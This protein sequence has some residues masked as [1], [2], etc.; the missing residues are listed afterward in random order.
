ME[1]T[2]LRS[3]HNKLLKVHMVKGFIILLCNALLIWFVADFSYKSGAH[4]HL[5][6]TT[7]AE[8][9]NSYVTLY[10]L[11]NKN[12]DEIIEFYDLELDSNIQIHKWAAE[13][14]S[15]LY[16]FLQL[17]QHKPN[18]EYYN[19]ILEYRLKYPSKNENIIKDMEHLTNN[20]AKTF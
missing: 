17:G 1:R 16:G 14:K 10:M 2:L 12:K 8:A 11:R 20:E 7:Y 15:L 18:T 3:R 6:T 4:D 19:R 13:N 9:A 5:A